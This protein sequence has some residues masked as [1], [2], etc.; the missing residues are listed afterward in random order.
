[1]QKL[2]A[3]HHPLD[4]CKTKKKA[5]VAGVSGTVVQEAREIARSHRARTC[6]SWPCFEFF[7]RCDEILMGS[8]VLVSL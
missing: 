8:W 7:S 4:I 6:R 1:M 2:V 3:Q 5:S